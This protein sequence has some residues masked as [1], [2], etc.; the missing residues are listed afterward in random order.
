M[1]EETADRDTCSG[2]RRWVD[3]VPPGK[4]GKEDSGQVECPVCGQLLEPSE[5]RAKMPVRPPGK[6]HDRWPTLVPTF[7][8]EGIVPDHQ[9]KE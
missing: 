2:S 3:V 6:I 8:H 7:T 9:V 4:T 1:L 5:S